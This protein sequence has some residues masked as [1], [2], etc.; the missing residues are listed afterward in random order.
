MS[1][2]LI[3]LIA[4]ASLGLIGYQEL[5]A[6]RGR[7]AGR[8]AVRIGARNYGRWYANPYGW[9]WGRGFQ[10]TSAVG[11]ARRGAAEMMRAQGEN[12]QA[13]AKAMIDYEEARSKYID[14]KKIA[15][16]SYPCGY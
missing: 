7:V 16:K 3:A 13:T 11:D 2:R 14:N 6:Q 10:G 15:E 4:V 5:L 1:R 12:R 8:S 9:G